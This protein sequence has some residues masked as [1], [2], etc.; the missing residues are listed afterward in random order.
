MEFLYTEGSEDLDWE[1]S[2]PDL[3]HRSAGVLPGT[4]VHL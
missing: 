1:R 2:K 3:K 4:G